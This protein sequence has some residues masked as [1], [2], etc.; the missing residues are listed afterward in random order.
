M[1]REWEQLM[2][3]R[4]SILIA[5]LIV[6]LFLRLEMQG[7]ENIPASGSY[8]IASNHLGRL[9]P[10]LIYYVS[11][12]RDIIMLVAEKYRKSAVWRWFVKQLDAIFVNRFEADFGAVRQALSRLRKG[13]VLV[14]APEGTRSKTGALIEGRPGVS[15]MAAKAG[16]P[17]IPVAITGTEDRKV[18]AS[19][20]RL[21]RPKVIARAGNAFTLPPLKAGRSAAASA[22]ASAGRDRDEALQEYTDEIMCRIAALLPPEYRG[23]YAEH[24][25]LKELLGQ[26]VEQPMKK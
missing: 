5:R 2:G 18:V 14:L 22:S 16:V 9:D 6:R 20:K 10:V 11:G 15:Y 23:V 17:I 12:R 13:G 19:L 3:Y 4:I 25:R 21:R 24:P 26:E 1:G 7:L 8:V